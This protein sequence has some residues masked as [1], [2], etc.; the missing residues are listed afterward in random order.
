M[1]YVVS[2]AGYISLDGKILLA[3]T[4]LSVGAIAAEL[5]YEDLHYFS[6]LFY[7]KTGIRPLRYRKEHR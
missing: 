7:A 4:N 2:G 6:N 1:E 5:G 3:E